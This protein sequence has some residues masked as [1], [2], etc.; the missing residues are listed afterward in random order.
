MR[1]N[2]KYATKLDNIQKY[3][4]C[5]VKQVFQVCYMKLDNIYDVVIL[6]VNLLNN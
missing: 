5:I 3:V 6:P 1:K 2:F 4:S